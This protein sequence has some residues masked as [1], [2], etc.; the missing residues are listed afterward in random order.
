MKDLKFVSPTN[1]VLPRKTIKD[2]KIYLNLNVYRNLHYLVSN[3]AK[4]VYNKVMGDQLENMKLKEKFSLLF[5]F[6]KKQN[7]KT[8][9]SNV[10]SI[11]EKFFCDALV[12]H[13]CIEDDNDDIIMSSHYFSGGVDKISPR[14]EV[15]ILPAMDLQRFKK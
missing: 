11:V 15:F 1:V 8:D 4:E 13:G 12:F 7:R 14:V 2:K 6:Y 5:V 10:L 9:R 3:D